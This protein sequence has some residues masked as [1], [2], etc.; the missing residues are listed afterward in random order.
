MIIPAPSIDSNFMAKYTN[1]TNTSSLVIDKF[2]DVSVYKV[3]NLKSSTYSLT[4][5]SNLEINPILTTNSIATNF[6][7]DVIVFEGEVSY[8]IN[9]DKNCE[10]PV[11][12]ACSFAENATIK[13][14]IVQEDKVTQ[15]PDW[16]SIDVENEFIKLNLDDILIQNIP[17][18]FIEQ[19]FG[20]PTK[21][22]YKKICF[23]VLPDSK[24][25]HL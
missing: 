22:I 23:K 13:Y 10:Y 16:I 17:C 25:S 6:T 2:I 11:R 7:A 21:Y 1:K 8:Y 14:R 12:L 24:C 3:S 18:Y 19:S 5:H 4:I 9:P 20:N 15:A